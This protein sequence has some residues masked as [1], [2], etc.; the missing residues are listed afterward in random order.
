MFVQTNGFSAVTLI[1]A[2]HQMRIPGFYV[3]SADQARLGKPETGQSIKRTLPQCR[4]LACPRRTHSK[5]SINGTFASCSAFYHK[6][7]FVMTLASQK[8]QRWQCQLA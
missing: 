7:A 2:Y 5:F 8:M 6:T 4:A 1:A 3:G